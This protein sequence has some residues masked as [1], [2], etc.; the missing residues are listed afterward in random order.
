MQRA[1]A[2]VRTVARALRAQADNIEARAHAGIRS[3]ALA[4][5]LRQ[6]AGRLDTATAALGEIPPKPT[7]T[8]DSG[9][10]RPRDYA[11]WK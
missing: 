10:L 8:P 6:L 1:I 2:Q 11:T 7:E 9:R 3:A 4:H 5:V